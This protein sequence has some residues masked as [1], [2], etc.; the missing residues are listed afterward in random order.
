[1]CIY[2]LYKGCTLC[3]S[4]DNS[5]KDSVIQDHKDQIESE[6]LLSLFDTAQTAGFLSFLKV[7]DVIIVIIIINIVVFILQN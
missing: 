7:V 3:P 6:R 5:S 1:M 2:V 4:W